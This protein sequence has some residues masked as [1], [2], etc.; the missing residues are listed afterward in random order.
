MITL[1]KQQHP[2]RKSLKLTN[3]GRVYQTTLPASLKNRE[4]SDEKRY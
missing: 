1:S 4:F 2:K 3:S